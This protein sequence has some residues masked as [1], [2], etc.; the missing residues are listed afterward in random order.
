MFFWKFT[1]LKKLQSE[2]TKTS[3][4]AKEIARGKML[5]GLVLL[6][7]EKNQPINDTLRREI[8]EYVAKE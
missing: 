3:D 2:S 6:K 4:C 5:L 1:R 8:E 7:A